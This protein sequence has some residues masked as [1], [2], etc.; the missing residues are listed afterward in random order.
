MKTTRIL[1]TIAAA[2]TLAGGIGF[3]YAQTATDNTQN[4]ASSN[5]TPMTTPT[6]STSPNSSMK[7]SNSTPAAKTTMPAATTDSVAGTTERAPKADRG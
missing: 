6:P 1:T 2:A 5:S 7:S 3:A 4:P